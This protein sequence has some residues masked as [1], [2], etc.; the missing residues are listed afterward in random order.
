MKTFYS[1]FHVI[2]E[3]F[4]IS[5]LISGI[6]GFLK[7]AIFIQ[8]G[9]SQRYGN[10]NLMMIPISIILYLQPSKIKLILTPAVA[11]SFKEFHYQID[12]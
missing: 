10:R 5:W 1:Q 4:Y 9:L 7:P 8:D 12:P 6:S 3:I 11:S 2:T